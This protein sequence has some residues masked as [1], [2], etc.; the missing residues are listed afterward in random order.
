MPCPS[1]VRWLPQVGCTNGNET[2][3]DGRRLDPPQGATLAAH[4]YAADAMSGGADVLPEILGER[5]RSLD[6][7]VTVR[8]LCRIRMFLTGGV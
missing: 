1:Q 6:D 3:V 7:R 4:C 5:P 2:V 8:P